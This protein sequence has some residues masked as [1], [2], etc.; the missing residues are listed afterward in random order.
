MTKVQG[1]MA[2][3]IFAISLSFI[4]LAFT[5][6]AWSVPN[7]YSQKM[8]GAQVHFLKVKDGDSPTAIL[9]R[10]G[11]KQADLTT[12]LR[13]VALPRYLTLSRGELYRVVTTPKRDFT[14]IKLYDPMHSTAYVFWRWNKQAGGFIAKAFLT[15]KRKEVSGPVNGSITSSILKGTNDFGIAWRF[16]DAFAYD[17]KD[18]SNKLQKGMRYKVVYEEKYD[19]TQMVGTGELLQAELTGDGTKELRYFVPIGEGGTFLN[20]RD[21]Q[22]NKPL[23]S[24]VGYWRVSSHFETRR[25]HPIKHRRQPHQGTDFEV[26][27]GAD[28]YAAQG[29]VVVNAGKK[30]GAGRFV[31]IQHPS[32]LETA[33][34]HMSAIDP[35]IHAGVVVQA[36]QKVGSIG[37]TGLCTRPHLHFA[38]RKSGNYLDPMKYIRSYPARALE[39]VTQWQKSGASIEDRMN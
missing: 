19:G 29:G 20:P 7:D 6:I 11:F 23:Y 35:L 28:V 4:N 24:P 30:R 21:S 31:V 9:T 33:Y 36:G 15:T 1:W 38:V 25:F 2:F 18:L 34:N 8:K 27:E 14:E 10:H 17:H 22:M 12:S 32:G 39:Q 26:P 5:N 3:F 13:E 37:C 16:L